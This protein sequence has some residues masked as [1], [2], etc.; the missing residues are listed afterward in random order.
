[1]ATM[2]PRGTGYGC[3]EWRCT[4]VRRPAELYC[5]PSFLLQRRLRDTCA[6]LLV[7]VV[8]FY[9]KTSQNGEYQT[10]LFPHY[11]LGPYVFCPNLHRPVRCRR[12]TVRQ[13][14]VGDS[15]VVDRCPLAAVFRLFKFI[16][17]VFVFWNLFSLF[18]CLFRI[19]F[20]FVPKTGTFR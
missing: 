17:I 7:L 16:I 12:S 10:L 19:P 8:K 9:P 18:S 20:P 15:D 1:M 11:C 13:R 6:T 4:G 2:T 5:I 14:A 3:Q